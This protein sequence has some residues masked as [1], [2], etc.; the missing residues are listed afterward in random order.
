[1]DKW[2]SYS[3]HV[4]LKFKAVFS[5][6]VSHHRYL[7]CILLAG[8]TIEHE[9]RMSLPASSAVATTCL[10][11]RYNDMAHERGIRT[12]IFMHLLQNIFNTI[13]YDSTF[14]FSFHFII[15]SG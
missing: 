4:F 15:K 11:F 3:V 6:R 14:S 10:I 1:M 9:K 2:I 13:P 5:V 8:V 7:L 12:H